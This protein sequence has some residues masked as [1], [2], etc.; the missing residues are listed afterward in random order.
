MSHVVHYDVQEEN[1]NRKKIKRYWDDYASRED[2]QE[3]CSGLSSDIRW[4]EGKICENEEAARNYISEN[5]KG[6]YDQL[7]VRFYDYPNLEKSKKYLNLKERLSKSER[8][9]YILEN[10]KYTET[11]SKTEFVGCKCCGSKISVKHFKGSFCPICR[12][13]M[14]PKSTLD[15]IERMR[16]KTKSLKKEL[17]VEEKKLQEK[18]KK[19]AKIKWL[20]KI[21]YHV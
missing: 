5:D 6:W 16:E 1:V 7:A 4:I 10:T 20:I 11:L 12:A 21:E 9:L 2:W 17:K 19:N 15:R 14:R 3:G 8:E 18:Q 13:D